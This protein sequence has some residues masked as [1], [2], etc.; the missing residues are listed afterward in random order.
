MATKTDSR[1]AKTPAYKKVSTKTDKVSYEYDRQDAGFAS[2]LAKH[3]SD[4]EIQRILKRAEDVSSGAAKPRG[5]GYIKGI[6]RVALPL[7]EA[8]K[9]TRVE[10][11]ATVLNTLIKEG[12]EVSPTT[13]NAQLS[14]VLKDPADKRNH[15]TWGL[16]AVEV[17][18]QRIYTID[19]SKITVPAKIMRMRQEDQS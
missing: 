7:I 19:G 12:L 1:K 18:G 4:G 13:V 11:S 2:I 8:G 14:R 5:K 16:Q 10:I 17:D 6:H 9:Y 15:N 3:A